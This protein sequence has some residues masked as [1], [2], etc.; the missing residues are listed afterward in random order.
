M[1]IRIDVDYPYVNRLKSFL[2]VFLRVKLGKGYLANAKEIAKMVN[3]SKKEV[4]CYWF[5]TIQTMPDAELMHMLLSKKHEICLH[6]VKDV[7]SE[8]WDLQWHAS[9]LLLDMGKKELKTVRYFNQ[10]GVR[11]LLAKVIWRKF[12]KGLQNQFPLQYFGEKNCVKLDMLCYQ[13]QDDEKAYQIA[14]NAEVIHIHPE[15]LNEN[16]KLKF[17]KRGLYRDVLERLLT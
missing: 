16:S 7:F 5:F 13:M 10:H 11:R 9:E 15:F 14:K 6:A 12:T 4:K 3:G 2:A 8:G 1:I 17:N